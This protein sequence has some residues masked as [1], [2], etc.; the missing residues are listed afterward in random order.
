M[1]VITKITQQQRRSDRYSIYIDDAYRLSL[2]V[3]AFRQAGLRTGDELSEAEITQLK[4]VSELGKAL[5]HAFRYLTLRLR[6]H[7]EVATYLQRKHYPEEVINQALEKL[8]QQGAI[9]DHRFA[10]A[11]VEDRLMFNPRSRRALQAELR[12]KGIA[13]DVVDQVLAAVDGDA[14]AD[15]LVT[16]ITEKRLLARYDDER[17]LIQYLNGKGFGYGTI[18]AALKRLEEATD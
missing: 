5:D 17:K 15:T 18:K 3:D 11:W 10:N 14:E 12:Q 9:D 6:S 2:S 8:E 1:P 13:P 16:L 4:T 7:S